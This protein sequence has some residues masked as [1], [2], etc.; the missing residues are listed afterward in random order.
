MQINYICLAMKNL[1]SSKF[2]A[3]VALTFLLICFGF[4][5]PLKIDQLQLDLLIQTVTKGQKITTKGEVYYRSSNGKLVTHF[6]YPM[7]LVSITNALGEMQSYDITRNSLW[8]KISAEYSSKQSFIYHFM[9]GQHND[10]G[11]PE[12]GFELTETKIDNGMV[13]TVWKYVG[14]LNQHVGSIIELV[15]EKRFPIYMSLSKNNITET[16]TY[17]TN[18]QIIGGIKM[19]MNIT[20]INYFE[21][22]SDSTITRKK[23]S[24]PQ[25]NN[26]VNSE[27][28]DFVIPSNAKLIKVNGK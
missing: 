24:N 22:G 6:S 1:K 27:Y 10:M 2:F 8:Q 4:N 15:H 20:E 21:G 17:Y 18:Y 25:I 9:T 5:T 28:L 23:Y 13:V 7:E 16:K 14:K 12:N 26:Q 11:L 19:P 3:P